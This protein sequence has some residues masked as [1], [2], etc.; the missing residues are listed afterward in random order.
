MSALTIVLALVW[1]LP[2]TLLA[3][4]ILAERAS[5]SV[6][7]DPWDTYRP[8]GEAWDRH[9][10]DAL[11]MVETSIYDD[12]AADVAARE[13]AGIDDEWLRFGGAR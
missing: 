12:L 1:G 8:D 2:L 9:V 6:V 10:N 4:A 11:A 13:A 3:V 5:A 7:T